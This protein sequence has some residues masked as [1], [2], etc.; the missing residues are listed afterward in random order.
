MFAE[1]DRIN[2]LDLDSFDATC[3][4]NL[5]QDCTHLTSLNIPNRLMSDTCETC[6][7]FEGCT[8]IK[9]VNFLTK[10]IPN[11]VTDDD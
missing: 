2:I 4:H 8:G 9:N 3:L 11:H 7:V 1:C 6:D 5:F 10:H